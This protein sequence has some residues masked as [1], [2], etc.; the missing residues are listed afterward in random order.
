MIQNKVCPY[1]KKRNTQPTPL[2]N[3][4]S[5]LINGFG[6]NIDKIFVGVNLA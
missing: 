2:A 5:G 6:E 4:Q 3:E 1:S